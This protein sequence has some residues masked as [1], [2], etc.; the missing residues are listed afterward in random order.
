MYGQLGV[1]GPRAARSGCYS[2]VFIESDQQVVKATCCTAT[3]ALLD[4]LLALGSA[5]PTALPAVHERLG[6]LLTC[7]DGFTYIGY[8]VERLAAYR[9]PPSPELNAFMLACQAVAADPSFDPGDAPPEQASVLARRL[10][11]LDM[12]GTGPAFLYLAELM[13]RLRPAID[14]RLEAISP[15]DVMARRN[16]TLVL[17]DPI[18]TM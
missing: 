17:A 13:N 12:Q 1:V 18:Y 6:P 10:A 5:A 8:R 7:P 15:K 14:A 9:V 3:Q 11:G 16:G 2:K 4:D